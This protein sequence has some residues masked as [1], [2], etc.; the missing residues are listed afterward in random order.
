MVHISNALPGLTFHKNMFLWSL[1]LFYEASWEEKV[2][3]KE[4]G[5]TNIWTCIVLHW[6]LHNNTPF[7]IFDKSW[8]L[9]K[10]LYWCS[11]YNKIKRK[12]SLLC[13]Y[14]LAN[15]MFIWVA[16]Y[17]SASWDMTH[18]HCPDQT[19]I[20]IVLLIIMWPH[21]VPNKGINI[22]NHPFK[23]NA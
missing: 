12:Q 2:L 1:T 8:S 4:L 17:L 22:C 20:N 23:T 3:D 6:K 10:F 7:L 16:L 11:C 5:Q 21:C 14:L 9:I 13:V 19:G 15:Q 18:K